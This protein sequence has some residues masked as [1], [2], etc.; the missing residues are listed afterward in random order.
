MSQAQTVPQDPMKN[1]P[2]N[3]KINF[4]VAQTL[5]P[6]NTEEAWK[7]A[8]MLSQSNVIPP[9]F[10]KQP[11]N[12]FI[13][14]GM[15]MAIGL[16]PFQAL[17]NIYIVNGKPSMYGDALIG[18]VLASPKCEYIDETFDEKT[19]TAR[20][21]CKRRGSPKAQVRTFSLAEA[22]LAGYDKKP[23]PWQSNLRRMIQM[24]AR[25]FGLRDTFADVLKGLRMLE[26]VVDYE[27]VDAEPMP[28]PR[29][30]SEATVV[31]AQR[32]EHENQDLNPNKEAL[33]G[34]RHADGPPDEALAALA[35]ATAE[36]AGDAQEPVEEKQ[37]E[38]TKQDEPKITIDQRKELMHLLKVNGKT[39]PDLQKWLGQTYGYTSTSEIPVNKFE[40]VS[41]WIQGKLV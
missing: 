14:I 12:C 28:M 16:D 22:R 41:K 15:G 11:A 33:E 37:P 26:E 29:R 10:Q 6:K 35:E 17:Q 32:V 5:M 1:L 24:R 25:G 18:V 21:E 39:S 9:A 8:T 19:M 7:L 30:I 4:G 2:A 13:A 23:G 40:A 3:K 20:I 27:I 38:P 34:Y 36:P 31:N